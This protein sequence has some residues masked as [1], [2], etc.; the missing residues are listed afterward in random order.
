MKKILSIILF[1]L[2]SV[3]LFSCGSSNSTG[4]SF[5]GG[6]GGDAEYMPDNI[7]GTATQVPELSDL[8][9]IYEAYIDLD[10]ENY[11]ECISSIQKEVSDAKGYISS[12]REN[13]N[14]SSKSAS[15]VI[16]IPTESY[17]SVKEEI[18]KLGKVTYSN[19]SVVD[20]TGNYI[21]VEARL[22]T[23]RAQKTALDAMLEK[24]TDVS[25]M[26]QIQKEI[27]NVNY[28]IESYQKQLNSYDN[29]IA[30]STV[31]LDVFQKENVSEHSDNAF[32]RIGNNFVACVS[33]IWSVIVEIFVFVIGYFPVFI[34]IGG[35]VV[36]IV[37]LRKRKGKRGK[38]EKN[39]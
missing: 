13:I 25:T 34:I 14:E 8:K 20:V 24:A 11:D 2:L 30:Y 31:N 3:A 12:L 7:T 17:N 10:V 27:A 5:N 9:L 35:V 1:L 39:S 4:D 21:D 32:V 23:L 26:L 38:N 19:H 15:I 16:R 22:Q 29:R 18:S 28:Q 33:G 6:A 37:F 36:L